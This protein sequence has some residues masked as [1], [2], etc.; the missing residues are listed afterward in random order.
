MKWNPLQC[1]RLLWVHSK[2][3]KLVWDRVA[4]F[5]GELV[6]TPVPDDNGAAGDSG[7]ALRVARQDAQLM[8]EQMR[9]AWL[10]F[11]H[12]ETCDNTLALAEQLGS[13]S[14]DPNLMEVIGT[15]VE[16][17]KFDFAALREEKK[18]LGPRRRGRRNA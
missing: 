7:A 1:V 4:A 15:P 11:L 2:P 16:Q 12:A 3:T 14:R 10:D 18:K 13:G 8:S 6:G 9:R 17:V 5:L